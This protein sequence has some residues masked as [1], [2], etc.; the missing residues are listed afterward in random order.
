MTVNFNNL[1]DINL[2]KKII[3]IFKIALLE[4][5]TKNNVSVNVTIVG[6]DRIRKLNHDFRNVDKVTDVLSFPL[7]EPYEIKNGEML[8][9]KI[10]TDLGDIAICK[11]KAVIQANDYKH[12]VKRE[13][14]FL[15]LHGFLHVLG[16]D[17][18][19][20]DEEE[21]MF[22]LQDKILKKAKVER[23]WIINVGI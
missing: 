11:S 18:I 21:I 2:R 1:T 17:H 19:K 23:W 20:K 5:N 9:N 14:C 8:N 16:Y 15:A 6:K 13:I 4:T 10:Q 3:Q 7:L 22:N 12:S